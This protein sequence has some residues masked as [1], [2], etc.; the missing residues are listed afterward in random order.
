MLEL[1]SVSGPAPAPEL[2]NPKTRFCEPPLR[3]GFFCVGNGGFRPTTDIGRR[4]PDWP[5]P[6]RT[7]HRFC[8]QGRPLSP[9]GEGAAD[10]VSRRLTAALRNPIPSLG[11]ARGRRPR[12]PPAPSLGVEGASRPRW[13]PVSS[14]TWAVRS[15]SHL[16][17][18]TPDSATADS[19]WSASSPRDRTH[20]IAMTVTIPLSTV[21]A[22]LVNPAS[23][24]LPST[25]SFE[26][27][28]FLYQLLRNSQRPPF[29]R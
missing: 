4:R 15:I 29:Q 3:R 25:Q 21:E 16:Y 7:R 24:S 13:T 14:N 18:S 28:S 23:K 12:G 17:P 10:P 22:T 9:V 26:R 6:T 8:K 11:I 20:G 2:I 1:V 5:V 19:I 27:R